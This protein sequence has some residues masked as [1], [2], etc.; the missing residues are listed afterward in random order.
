MLAYD[1]KQPWVSLS[2]AVKGLVGSKCRED[3][4]DVIRSAAK[5][6][7]ELIYKELRLS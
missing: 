1:N 2:K 5:M 3:E 7:A 6:T 4:H